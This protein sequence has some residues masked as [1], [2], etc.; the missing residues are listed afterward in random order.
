MI[1]KAKTSKLP[2]SENS[3]A[4]LASSNCTALGRVLTEALT[5][6][7]GS[8]QGSISQGT[9]RLGE[10][11]VPTQPSQ[12]RSQWVRPSPANWKRMGTVPWG[13]VPGPAAEDSES[14]IAP[15]QHGRVSGL[16]AHSSVFIKRLFPCTVQTTG[17]LPSLSS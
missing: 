6:A 17:C 3:D 12:C 10:E 11:D 4:F 15:S 16:R 8:A 2:S 9:L 5:A 1:A 13:L 7:L 14:L